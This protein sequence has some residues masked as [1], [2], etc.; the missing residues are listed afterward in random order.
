VLFHLG[1]G[2]VVPGP[3]AFL[4]SPDDLTFVLEGPGVGKVQLEGV[5]TDGQRITR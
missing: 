4:Q 2:D 1:D 5:D 3:K